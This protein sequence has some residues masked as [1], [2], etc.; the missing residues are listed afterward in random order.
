MNLQTDEL[1]KENAI[2]NIG[3]SSFDASKEDVLSVKINS[4]P[5][6]EIEVEEKQIIEFPDGILGFDDIKKFAILEEEDSPFVWLQACNEPDLAFVVIQ[7]IYFMKEYQLMISSNEL[8]AVK[9]K[10]ADE[11]IVFAI[12]TIP[13]DN[14]SDMTANLQGPIIVNPD[15]RIGRQAISLSDKYIVKH[16]IIQELENNEKEAK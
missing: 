10:S 11:L 9:A 1:V 16:K 8:E 6:G 7:P 4:K 15:K 12:V 5:F 14:P 2:N 13:V 3:C